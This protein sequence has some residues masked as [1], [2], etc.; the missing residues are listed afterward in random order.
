MGYAAGGAALGGIVAGPAGAMVGG[1]VGKCTSK[2]MFMERFFFAQKK[3][4]RNAQTFNFSYVPCLEIR[5]WSEIHNLF[6]RVC[7]R[8]F[9]SG[10]L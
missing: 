2:N 9:T 3:V 10:E 7:L 6:Y 8:V 4:N 5:F 1:I